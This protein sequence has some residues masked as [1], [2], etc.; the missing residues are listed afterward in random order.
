MAP[1]PMASFKL[2]RST[3][4]SH[5][6][7]LVVDVT[8]RINLALALHV[9]CP[10]NRLRFIFLHQPLR[11]PGGLC[12]G[13]QAHPANVGAHHRCWRCPES[14]CVAYPSLEIFSVTICN[15]I[16]ATSVLTT[17]RMDIRSGMGNYGLPAN[18]RIYE[19]SFRL[20]QSL[21]AGGTHRALGI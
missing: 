15:R 18:I 16:M 8:I 14:C 20:Q 5:N 2:S 4:I 11:N 9:H 6:V 3:I 10:Q 12:V 7:S 21:R 19:T 1:F 17:I 13:R